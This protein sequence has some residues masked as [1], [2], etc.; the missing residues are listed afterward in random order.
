VACDELERSGEK[1]RADGGRW[2][3]FGLQAYRDQDVIG[4]VGAEGVMSG[5]IQMEH[6]RI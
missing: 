6:P 3:P 5:V 1:G 4:L 2:R